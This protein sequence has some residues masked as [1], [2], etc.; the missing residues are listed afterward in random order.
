MI[1]T[2]P[3]VRRAAQRRPD[4]RRARTSPLLLTAPALVFA[5]AQWQAFTDCVQSGEF[6]LT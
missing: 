2:P 6:D 5:P 1:R 4:L 3:G